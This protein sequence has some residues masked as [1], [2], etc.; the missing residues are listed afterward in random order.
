MVRILEPWNDRPERTETLT[1][2][3]FLHYIDNIYSNSENQNI[4]WSIPQTPSQSAPG[5]MSLDCDLWSYHA[6]ASS[7][8]FCARCDHNENKIMH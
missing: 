5:N 6:L 2:G 8:H 4:L 3:S 1:T 7:C